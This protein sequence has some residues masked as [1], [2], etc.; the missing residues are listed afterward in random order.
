MIDSY[1]TVTSHLSQNLA[2]P[3]T[4]GSGASPISHTMLDLLIVFVPHLPR[5]QSVAL[6]NATATSGMLEHADATVQ[7]KSYRLLKRL[8]EAGRLGVEIQNERVEEFV[9]KLNVFGGGVGPGAQ[10]VR[11]LHVHCV[12]ERR[13]TVMG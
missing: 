10:R 6:F 4:A 13:E 12:F 2:L 11:L 9:K 7:K 5:S 8:L 3:K 1:T